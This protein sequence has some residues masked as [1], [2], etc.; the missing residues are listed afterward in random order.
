M[1]RLSLT[2]LLL[3]LVMVMG[4]G[5]EST[6]RT[7]SSW[8]VDELPKP[9]KVLE[10]SEN[11][12]LWNRAKDVAEIKIPEWNVPPTVYIYNEIMFDGQ[13]RIWSFMDTQTVVTQDGELMLKEF[14]FVFTTRMDDPTS[15]EK[16]VLA[17]YFRCLYYRQ[18]IVDLNF[19]AAH[20]IPELWVDIMMDIAFP[21]GNIPE[22]VT[23]QPD[24][25]PQD[26]RSKARTD[27]GSSTSIAA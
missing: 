15:I 10:T 18:S 7:T 17:S 8:M 21:D 6:P 22:R 25:L 1:K 20:P 19:A 5:V 26:T 13:E 11:L 3:V 12:R 2:S 24:F 16:I 9:D 14:M 27:V 4:C 23:P